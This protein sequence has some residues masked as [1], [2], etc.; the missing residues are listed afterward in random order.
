MVTHTRRYLIGQHPGHKCMNVISWL[1]RNDP[2]R[3]PESF[4]CN[5]ASDH[6]QQMPAPST[7][8]LITGQ[9]IQ[10]SM[11][12]YL[13]QIQIERRVDLQARFVDLVCSQLLLQLTPDRLDKPGRYAVCRGLKVE[14]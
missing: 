9:T 8:P 4:H 5:S 2:V 12:G 1:R 13:L 11:I 10:K 6:I 7:L 3:V 14:S